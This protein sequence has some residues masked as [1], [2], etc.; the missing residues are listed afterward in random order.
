MEEVPLLYP[1]ERRGLIPFA[2]FTL[3]ANPLFSYKS[4]SLLLTHV[5]LVAN[6]DTPG[7]IFFCSVAQKG[8]SYSCLCQFIVEWPRGVI[9]GSTFKRC[10]KRAYLLISKG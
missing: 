4:V 3:A 2:H 5:Q 6:Y 10:L 1:T 9:A 7:F 8:L